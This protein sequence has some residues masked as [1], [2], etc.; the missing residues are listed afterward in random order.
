MRNLIRAG[1]GLLALTMNA[2]ALA[3]ISGTSGT[4]NV[5][6]ETSGTPA[7]FDELATPR[8]AL[9]DVYFGG[10]KIAEEAADTRPGML[11]FRAAGDILAKLPELVAGT[12]VSSALAAELPTN[13]SEAC[14]AP[15]EADCGLLAPQ[16]IGII[17]DED[18]FRVDLFVNPKFL[19]VAPAAPQ[20]YLP[21]PSAPLSLTNALGLAASGTIGGPVVYN[22]Q[23]R[24][25]IG[26]RNARLRADTSIASGV[27]LV[28]DDFVAEIDRKDLRYSAGLFWAP[29]NDFTGRRRI[30][31]AGVGTQFDTWADQDGLHASPLILFLP[32][33]ARVE[34]LV[35]GRLAGSRSYSAGNVQLDTSGLPDGAYAVLLRIH[36]L[37]GSTREERR[38]FV[39]Y[40][41][42]AP[43][44]HPIFYAYGGIL[45]NARR[46]QPITP[47]RSAYYQLGAAWR[48]TEHIALD[49]AVLGTQKKAL[50]EGGAWLIRGGMRLRA[51]GLASTAGDR[52]A[53]LQ[54]TGGG[55]PFN[56][57]FDLRRVWSSS[58]GPLIPLPTYASSFDINP[59]TGVQL[60][61]GSYTQATASLG[62]RLGDGFLSVVGSY[63]KDRNLRPDYSIGPSV[64]WPLVSRGPFQLVLEASAQRTRGATAGF[65]GLRVAF[66]RGRLSML[67]TLGRSFQTGK[68]P[69]GSDLSRTVSTVS[70]Q[71][72]S[73]TE[74]RTLLNLEAGMDRNVDSST[75]HG[76]G[77]LYSRFGNARADLVHGLE[78][79]HGTQFDLALQSGVAI[80][81]NAVSLG[82][83][84]LEQSAIIV[85]LGGHAPGAAFKVMVNEVARGRIIPGQRLS[86]FLP[87]Y[88][89]YKVRLVPAGSQMVS[90]D[91]TAREITL[92]PGNVQPLAWR[93]EAFFTVFGQAVSGAGIPVADARVQTARGIAQ[94][95]ANGYFQV[96]VASRELIDIAKADGAACRISL[97][98]VAVRNDFA[99]IGKVVCE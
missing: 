46:N 44:G 66:N 12:E 56:I 81:R 30:I 79:A 4:A 72:S 62:M 43:I 11:R 28:V 82:G 35:D 61:S 77:S 76:G 37:N 6:F 19:R 78:G 97:G 15:G 22:M 51:A 54:A 48:L 67:N 5:S 65:A 88:R 23:N 50:V 70:A 52:G 73:E 71:Y 53:L 59:A 93:A 2:Q 80:G 17:Y 25:L 13:S 39:K 63:R 91:S 68:G 89:T 3:G 1:L 14:T 74:D 57:S 29:G 27:G 92:Y 36:E 20:G 45:A 84:D 90:Y 83:R 86:L 10:R 32:G 87:G 60:A 18:R 55:G 96:D 40:A 38:F 47:T 49:L 26:M 69:G 99:S 24:T 16:V 8:I 42:V 33:P 94:T 75:L 7:G 85:S 41:Q 9:V 95:D 98:D 31:G 64:N 58:G 34:L 21:G